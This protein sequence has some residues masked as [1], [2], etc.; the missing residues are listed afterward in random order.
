MDALVVDDNESLARAL[1]WALR[2]ILPAG[3]DVKSTHDARL[4]GYLLVMD[5]GL[6]VAIIDYLLPVMLG[7]QIINEAMKVR[8]ELRG[9]IIVSSGMDEFPEEVEKLLFQDLGCRKLS[10]PVDFDELERMVLEIIGPQ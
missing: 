9:K 4:G 6:K 8:P 10:K 2:R 1:E 5:P 7:D 3:W